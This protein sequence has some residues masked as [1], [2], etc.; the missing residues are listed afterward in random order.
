MTNEATLT[1]P[2]DGHT[3][4]MVE[5]ADSAAT[6]FLTRDYGGL[7]V[8]FAADVPA[9]LRPSY[10]GDATVPWHY[11][12]PFGEQAAIAAGTRPR[13]IV[14]DEQHAV[15]ISG[16]DAPDLL[17]RLTT[18]HFL[19]DTTS[20]NGAGLLTLSAQGHINQQLTVFTGDDTAIYGVGAAADVTAFSDHVTRMKFWSDVTVTPTVLNRVVI[21]GGTASHHGQLAANPAL[22]PLVTVAAHITWAGLCRTDLLVDPQ[23]LPALITTL[24]GDGISLAGM[25]AY[26]ALRIAAGIARREPDLAANSIPHESHHLL[27]RGATPA[28][29]HLD[30]GCY[31]GQETVARVENLGQPPKLLVVAHLDG[32]APQLPAPGTAIS[33][34]RRTVGTIGSVIEHHEY[35]PIALALVKRSAVGK[36]GTLTA[37][38]Q[39]I[40][41]D[42]D[43]LPPDSGPKAGRVA[44]AKLR[45]LDPTDD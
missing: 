41:I 9:T 31:P 38:G 29:V 15:R 34:G 35:G 32:S 1:P 45:G 42:P 23:H 24:T 4:A 6:G 37:A 17:H 22:Q 40:A 26:E 18:Q 3:P 33:N 20:I 43:S 25:M 28:A 5:S 7:I 2:N 12:D 8:D 21:L 10:Q 27:G 36:T 39:S 16:A 14:T 19:G 11:G 13:V 44:L 30:K